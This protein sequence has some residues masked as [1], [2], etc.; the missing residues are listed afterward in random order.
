MAII[1]SVFKLPVHL[2]T[3]MPRNESRLS[4]TKVLKSSRGGNDV[5]Q[6]RAFWSKLTLTRAK[7]SIAAVYL[8]IS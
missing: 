7:S 2:Y 8:S 6:I 3:V 4:L 1:F 5:R